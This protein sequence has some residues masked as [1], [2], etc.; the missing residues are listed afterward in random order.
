MAQPSTNA[1]I[2]KYVSLRVAL[3]AIR[4]TRRETYFLMAALVLGCAI[5]EG[6][7]S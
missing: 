7:R 1:A 6:E 5:I 4:A 3:I 2:R